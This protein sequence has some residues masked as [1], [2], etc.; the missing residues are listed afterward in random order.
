MK[1]AVNFKCLSKNI[2]LNF[3]CPLSVDRHN[4][5]FECQT[6]KLRA[7]FLHRSQT[8]HRSCNGGCWHHYAGTRW[9]CQH[10]PLTK[11]F[12]IITFIHVLLFICVQEKL[13]LCQMHFMAHHRL[14]ERSDLHFITDFGLMMDGNSDPLLHFAL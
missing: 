6:G 5:L 11:P 14:L 1:D 8:L 3:L 13:R 7:E 10:C 12:I 4:Q 9:A 2:V